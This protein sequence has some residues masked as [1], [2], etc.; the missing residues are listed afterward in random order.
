MTIVPM[1]IGTALLISIPLFAQNP[2]I[3]HA[4]YDQQMASLQKTEIQLREQIA[5]EQ[6]SILQ[7]KKKIEASRE[8]I[9]ALR[10]KKLEL[11]G[12]TEN[13]LAEL[14]D[15]I[16]GL[17]DG[18]RRLL[19]VGDDEFINDAGRFQIFLEQFETLKKKPATRL[20]SIK[21]GIEKISRMIAQAET[22]YLALAEQNAAAKERENTENQTVSSSGASESYTVAN[23]GGAPETLYGIASKMY[24]DPYQWIRIYNANKTVIDSNFNRVRKK[25]ELKSIAEPSDLIFPGQVLVIPR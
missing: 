3:S 13:G 15:E 14:Q 7:L 16:K 12:I 22:R 18:L 4:E 6:A 17:E 19:R 24:G 2:P 21:P 23:R 25:S 9:S 1:Y 10:Q 8:R 5:Q 20:R 11:V